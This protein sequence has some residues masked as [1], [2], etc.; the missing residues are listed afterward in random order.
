MAQTGLQHFLEEIKKQPSDLQQ[1]ILDVDFL[2]ILRKIQKDKNLHI[3]Q[4]AALEDITFK[5]MLGE[6]AIENYSKEIQSTLRIDEAQARE[7]ST[8][9]STS[10]F[11]PIRVRFEQIQ[12]EIEEENEERELLNSDD[13]TDNKLE[14]QEDL[15][16]LTP[17]NI[18]ADIEDPTPSVGEVHETIIPQPTKPLAVPV[19]STTQTSTSS[20]IPQNPSSTQ[21]NAP[22]V[23]T[24]DI[25][26]GATKM[27]P[28]STPAKAPASI[29]PLSEAPIMKAPVA[30]LNTMPTQPMAPATSTAATPQTP[31]QPPVRPQTPAQQVS[32][33]LASNLTEATVNKPQQIKTSLD[34][35]K[36][37]I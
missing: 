7:L 13:S 35:Y 34:P 36:E 29:T 28:A 8:L 26:A 11:E 31:P 17:E 30:A 12:E 21:P 18:L 2:K 25:L 14:T 23:A 9:V 32:T 19:S 4:G 22:K 27:F 24:A 33:A 37:A 15:S 5:T 20:Q 16:S 1:A 3:D 10:I 6:I